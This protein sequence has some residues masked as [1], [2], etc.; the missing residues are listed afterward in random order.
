[1][2]QSFTNAFGGR[3]LCLLPKQVTKRDMCNLRESG[4]K[5]RVRKVGEKMKHTFSGNDNFG[6]LRPAKRGKERAPTPLIERLALIPLMVPI[7][8]GAVL[9]AILS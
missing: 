8:I 4:F 2:A 5:R 7:F 6:R 3:F 1:M 9:V